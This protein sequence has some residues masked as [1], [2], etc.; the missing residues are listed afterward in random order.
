MSVRGKQ[1]CDRKAVIE[2]T[3]PSVFHPQVT[4]E[5]QSDSTEQAG[6]TAMPTDR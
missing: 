1:Q 6:K 3:A 2:S 4:K 5:Q